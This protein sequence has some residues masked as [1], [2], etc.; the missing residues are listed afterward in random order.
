MAVGKTSLARS[1]FA[2]LRPSRSFVLFLKKG[3]PNDQQN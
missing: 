1:R 2:A 3:T